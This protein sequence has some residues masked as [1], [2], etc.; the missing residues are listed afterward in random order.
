MVNAIEALSVLAVASLK[1]DPYGKVAYDVGG[2]MKTY[3]LVLDA[4]Q[5]FVEGMQPHW[6]DVE[7]ARG[8]EDVD[9]VCIKLRE[10]LR[11]MVD[12]FEPYAGDFRIEEGIIRTAR[13]VAGGKVA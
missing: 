3:I 12:A 2:I 8:S 1:E 7:G 11:R 5:R 10:G 9:L 6:T 13:M 4:L